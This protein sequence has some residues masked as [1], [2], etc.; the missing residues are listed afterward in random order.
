MGNNHITNNNGTTT[1]TS[2]YTWLH[3]SAV[4]KP[5]YA[6]VQ[7]VRW[8]IIT[9][10]II[11]LRKQICASSINPLVEQSYI[12]NNNQSTFGFYEIIVAQ[13]IKLFGSFYLFLTIAKKKKTI[14]NSASCMMLHSI[15][16]Y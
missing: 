7:A 4:G 10:L 16:I 15:Q 14:F 13:N 12:Y 1:T 9:T 2:N 11:M 6:L 5:A 8:I 3:I